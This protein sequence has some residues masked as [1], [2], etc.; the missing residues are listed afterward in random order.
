MGVKDLEKALDRS[1]W[2]R[3]RVHEYIHYSNKPKQSGPYSGQNSR[4]GNSANN[5]QGRPLRQQSVNQD[6]FE[7]HNLQVPRSNRYAPLSTFMGNS[8]MVYQL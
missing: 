3:I 6:V 8:P 4:Q 7:N 5:N 2:P 1:I